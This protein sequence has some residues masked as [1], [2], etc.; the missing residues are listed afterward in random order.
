[1]EAMFF[2]FF[3]LKQIKRFHNNDDDDDEVDDITAAFLCSGLKPRRKWSYKLSSFPVYY[4][5][6][7]YFNQTRILAICKKVIFVLVHLNDSSQWT[8]S[9]NWIRITSALCLTPCLNSFLPC[10]AAC[11]K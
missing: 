6:D 1:M 8:D 7:V 5:S 4:L 2:F 10:K 11:A 3:F 9:L